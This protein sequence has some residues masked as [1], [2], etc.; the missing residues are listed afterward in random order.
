MVSSSMLR[1]CFL[2][3]IRVGHAHE[4]LT[5][6]VSAL[7]MGFRVS[8]EE[9]MVYSFGGEGEEVRSSPNLFKV[10]NISNQQRGSWWVGSHISWL[11]SIGALFY[12]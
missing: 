2:G 7:Y 12:S 5:V 11:F 8:Q 9:V 3:I 1:S 4:I 10:L 6:V